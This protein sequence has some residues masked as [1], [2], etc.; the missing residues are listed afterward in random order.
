M[1]GNTSRL[2]SIASSLVRPS[3][4]ERVVAQLAETEAVLK[5]V[6][7]DSEPNPNAEPRQA[8]ESV[9]SQKK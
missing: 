2:P 8:S 3:S 4:T 7:N 5:T 9:E 6:G 1:M